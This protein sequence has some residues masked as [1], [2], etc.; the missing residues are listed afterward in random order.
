[1]KTHKKT[2]S[3]HAA[4]A[5][6]KYNE[7]TEH[8]KERNGCAGQESRE[9]NNDGRSCFSSFCV[10]QTGRQKIPDHQA[11]VQQGLALYQWSAQDQWTWKNPTGPRF[12][13]GRNR[14]RADKPEHGKGSVYDIRHGLTGKSKFLAAVGLKI[15]TPPEFK[16]R[17]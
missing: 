10:I 6:C 1:M 13:Q 2:F 8:R 12:W 7:H 17:L 15:D 16:K 9:R 11:L 14:K 4:S 5:T 3:S